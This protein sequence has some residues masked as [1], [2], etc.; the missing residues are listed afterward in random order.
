MR[1]NQVQWGGN[2]LKAGDRYTTWQA[3]PIPKRCTPPAPQTLDVTPRDD[4]I[5]IVQFLSSATTLLVAAILDPSPG[6]E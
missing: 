2:G 6:R 3:T 4:H 5:E 1:M